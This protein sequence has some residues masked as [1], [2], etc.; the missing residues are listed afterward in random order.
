NRSALLEVRQP[1]RSRV[2]RRSSANRPSLLHERRR[3]GVRTEGVRARQ[4]ISASFW[5]PRRPDG[6]AR[7]ASIAGL[8]KRR[9]TPPAGMHR[10]IRMAQLC[11]DGPSKQPVGTTPARE[12][13]VSRVCEPPQR[14]S[15]VTG[16]VP[17]P[18][19]PRESAPP[20]PYPKFPHPE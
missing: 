18:P 20:N 10:R 19:A 15:P 8:C 6:K 9:A 5:P 11:P 17:P 12:G 14:C 3:A 1:P 7:G 16:G 2:P 13:G 4:E